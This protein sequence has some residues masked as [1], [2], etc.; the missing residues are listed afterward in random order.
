MRLTLLST[1]HFTVQ[2]TD[3]YCIKIKG[4]EG[5]KGSRHFAFPVNLLDIVSSAV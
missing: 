4:T 1:D 2:A 3:M 5:S